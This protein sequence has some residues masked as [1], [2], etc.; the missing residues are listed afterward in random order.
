MVKLACRLYND[1]LWIFLLLLWR[2]GCPY[3]LKLLLIVHDSLVESGLLW[4]EKLLIGRILYISPL[5]RFWECLIG[6]NHMWAWTVLLLVI[7][8]N[9]LGEKGVLFIFAA[10]YL[11]VSAE[12]V[13]LESNLISLI[14]T[15]DELLN[16]IFNLCCV[17]QF[18]WGDLLCEVMA[19]SQCALHGLLIIWFIQCHVAFESVWAK[20]DTW[21]Q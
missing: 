8:V 6:G 18:I 4:L 9:R 2:G 3:D 14:P 1:L 10:I 13:V 21:L 12:S 15:I 5:L 11:I 17:M 16:N 7:H 20:V 19:S